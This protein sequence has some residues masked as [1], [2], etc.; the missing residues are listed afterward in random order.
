LRRS[1]AL[2]LTL[3]LPLLPGCRPAEP[4]ADGPKPPALDS[5]DLL[6]RLVELP[7]GMTVAANDA[8]RIALDAVSDGVS[9]SV[10]ITVGPP[11]PAGVN[12]VDEANSYGRGLEAAGGKYYGGHQLVT[13]Y[14][15]GFQ[16]R[17]L[18]PGGK[19]EEIRALLLHPGDRDRLMVVSLAYPP[20]DATVSNARLNQVLAVLGALEPLEAGTAG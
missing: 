9:G 17:V 7:E 11:T 4:A 2:L 20:G 5:P 18:Q 6:L 3:S 12:L 14:G 15:S 16:I 8:E 13:P 19:V 1:A 10:T